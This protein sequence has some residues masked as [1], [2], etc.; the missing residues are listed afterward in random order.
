[1]KT[2]YYVESVKQ[3]EQSTIA[4]LQYIP[5]NIKKW[6][7]ENKDFKRYVR[8]T[9]EQRQKDVIQEGMYVYAVND[10]EYEIA[11]EDPR[12]L[13]IRRRYISLIEDLEQQQRELPQSTYDNISTLYTYH[14]NVGHG[15]HTLIVFQSNNNTHIWMVD[16]SD[17]DYIQHRK[18]NSNI[19][20]CI[21]HVKQKFHLNSS[22]HIY[23]VMLTHPHYDHFSGFQYYINQGLIDAN[24][25]VYINLKYNI[26]NHNYN[27]LLQ[28]LYVLGTQIIEPFT[29]NSNNNIN[30]LYPD[31][32]TFH[33][34]LSFN[35]QSSVYNIRFDNKSYFVFP[36]DLEKEGWN[37][38]D[39]R[40]CLPYMSQTHYYAISHHGSIN[41]HLRDGVC[42]RCINSV[43]DC[44]FPSAI[45]VLMGRDKAYSGIYSPKVLADFNS[46]ILFSEKDSLNNSCSF[47]EI[48]L[49]SGTYKN[50]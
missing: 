42:C 5:K 31:K 8:R 16:C 2:L 34:K 25:N 18:Y 3:L 30:I 24:T 40:K 32:K 21:N 37:L 17:F 36:G 19:D 33:S 50:L 7:L 15:N 39:V 47:L 6:E 10:G 20:K 26:A 12:A 1:M 35:N 41:G 23:V 4:F 11:N 49:I 38:M 27:N 13:Q 46:R 44:L 9:V 48:N 43:K 28:R 29:Y 22:I 14:V 45:T